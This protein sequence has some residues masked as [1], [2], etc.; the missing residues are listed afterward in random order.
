M[1]FIFI[2]VS[3]RGQMAE[4]MMGN[5]RTITCMVKEFTLGRMEENMKAITL[6]IKSTGMVFI[7][8]LTVVNT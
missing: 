3:I 7:L 4:D 2:R 5:G 6:M 8:G 1:M